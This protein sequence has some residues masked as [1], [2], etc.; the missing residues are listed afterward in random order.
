MFDHQGYHPR[1]RKQA[2]SALL[3]FFLDSLN[4][5]RKMVT[6][7]RQRITFFGKFA[8]DPAGDTAFSL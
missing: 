5:R 3:W 2:R 6:R 1:P 7:G 4:F 8:D